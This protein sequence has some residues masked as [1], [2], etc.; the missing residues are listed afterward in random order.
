MRTVRVSEPEPLDILKFIS[1]KMFL[2][3]IKFKS[4]N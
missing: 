1:S 3:D 4:L 2:S